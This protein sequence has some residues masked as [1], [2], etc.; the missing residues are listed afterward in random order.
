MRAT[1]VVLGL[2]LAGACSSGSGG[3]GGGSSTSSSS[4]SSSSGSSSGSSGSG[5][6][7]G[8]PAG[9]DGGGGS[10]GSNTATCQTASDCK[11]HAQACAPSCTCIA[12]GVN[13][14]APD[15][16]DGGTVGKCTPDPCAGHTAT[17]DST[18]TC[19]LQ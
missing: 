17:C 13:E 11:T 12:L 2:L 10:S 1:W 3:T 5:S 6:S 14:P 9:D 8:L 4:G 7:S 18:G 19:V 15:C 16:G